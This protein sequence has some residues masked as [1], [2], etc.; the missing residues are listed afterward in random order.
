MNPKYIG[1]LSAIQDPAV[2][3]LCAEMVKDMEQKE[4]KKPVDAVSNV[5]PI[6]GLARFSHPPWNYR[7]GDMTDKH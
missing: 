7:Y 5:G 6:K 1:L 4:D 3:R 2:K